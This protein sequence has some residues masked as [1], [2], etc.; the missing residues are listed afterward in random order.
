MPS[1][2]AAIE[3]DSVSI[4]N[5]WLPFQCYPKHWEGNIK[6][7]RELPRPELKI[8]SPQPGPPFQ[9]KSACK[10]N[11]TCSSLDPVWDVQKF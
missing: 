8:G 9:S 1:D 11:E 6:L 10:V 7:R 4:E 3:A 2:F 5:S